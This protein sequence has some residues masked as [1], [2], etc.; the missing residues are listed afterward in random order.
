ML[1]RIIDLG[2]DLGIVIIAI[3]FLLWLLIILAS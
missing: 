3:G 2:I 1:N